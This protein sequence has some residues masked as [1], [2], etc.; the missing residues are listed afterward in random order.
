MFLTPTNLSE[1]IIH[2]RIA[3]YL[4]RIT[5]NT[6]NH[7][8]LYGLPSVGKKTLLYAL[9][10]NLYKVDTLEIKEFQSEL[11]INNNIVKINY[12]KSLYHYEINLYEY[13]LYD[14]NI[15][16]EFIKEIISTT[17][18]NNNTYKIIILHKLDN[19]SES[20]HLSLRRI[21]EKGTPNARFI[22]TASKI[23]K[24]NEA[25]RSRFINFRIPFPKNNEL[26]KYLDFH[27]IKNIKLLD[28]NHNNNLYCF[29]MLLNKKTQLKHIDIGESVQKIIESK[30]LHFMNLL[31]NYIYKLHLIN[32][33]CNDIF[34]IFIK[35][36]I[37]N[38]KYTEEKKKKIIRIAS[39]LEHK[40]VLSN[41]FFFCIEN[42]FLQVRYIFMNNSLL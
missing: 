24:I 10:R 4:S 9:I 3:E 18:V 34:T 39:E 25:I 14:K 28:V 12:A 22:V 16:N 11:K 36:M 27:N 1:F 13:G 2:K 5:Y 26:Q 19:C 6:L 23:N 37:T 21:I 17:N 29:C 35:Y 33:S 15:I 40:S 8:L 31:R 41:K 38:N 7:L 30:K 20:C 42:F 32:Y